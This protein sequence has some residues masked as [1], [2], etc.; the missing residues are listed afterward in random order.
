MKQTTASILVVEDEAV[1]SLDIQDFLRRS[2]YAVTGAVTTGEEALEVVSSTRPDL[3]LMDIQ[4]AG[5]LDGIETARSMWSK[6]QLPSIFLTAFTDEKTLKRAQ[7]AHPHGYLL[8]PFEELE[9]KATIDIALDRQQEEPDSSPDTNSTTIGQESSAT[10]LGEVSLT[11]L[12]F[13]R[14]VDPFR[15]LQRETLESLASHS[16]F[17]D[18]DEDTYLINEGS[19]A[20]EPFILAKGRLVVMKRSSQGKEFAADI[21]APGDIFGVAASL[22]KEDAHCSVIS[23]LPSKILRLPTNTLDKIGEQDLRIYQELFSFSWE[24]LGRSVK[25]LQIMAYE[26]VEYRIAYV[27]A[28]ILADFW[29]KTPGQKNYHIEITRQQLA[30]LAGTTPETAIR[31]TKIMEREG[32]LDLRRAGIIVLVDIPGLQAITN[33]DS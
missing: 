30:E 16:H 13:L 14:R 26:R 32:L 18:L 22:S 11:P 28:E 19:P 8:K 29:T 31:I 23:H 2:G 3:V 15:N 21:L 25:M 5:K 24:K 33:E 12:D 9:L 20:G 17:Y 7:L 1:T 27:L 10:Q 6:F 4:L